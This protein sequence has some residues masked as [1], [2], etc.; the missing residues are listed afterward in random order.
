MQLSN[1]TRFFGQVA[2]VVDA[3]LAIAEGERVA[4]LGPSG[5]GKT[6]LL[7]LIAG[8]E[9]PD[10]G[11]IRMDGQVISTPRR[12]IPPHMRGIGF[13]FQA[14]TLW[15]HMTVS[16]N[17]RFGLNALDGEAQR[18]RTGEMLTAMAL[19]GLEDRRPDQLSGGEARRVA[20]ARSLAPRPRYL[21]LDEPLTN[22][23]AAL[24]AT[25]IALLLDE[26]ERTGATM[27]YV[28]HDETEARL[29][30][31]SIVRMAHGRIE[32]D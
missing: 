13:V 20:L 31:R 1:V 14:P 19:Q 32:Q 11:E 24:K 28:T 7:R 8:L 26:L 22:L 18:R 12:M 2:A 6:T 29:L 23:D 30:A 15:P 9:R 27:L 25:M 17:I 10:A 21:L 16:Q 5:S 3:S 4:I